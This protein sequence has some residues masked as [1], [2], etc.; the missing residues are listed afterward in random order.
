MPA[1]PLPGLERKPYLSRWRDDSFEMD[2]DRAPGLSG[3][4][5]SSASAALG[6]LGPLGSSTLSVH[7]PPRSAS[8]NVALGSSGVMTASARGVGGGAGG[9]S[10][11]PDASPLI[12]RRKVSTVRS[13]WLERS[14]NVEDFV[15]EID[16]APTPA[17]SAAPTPAMGGG[18]T[19]TKDADGAGPG[20]GPGM[21]PGAGGYPTPP[22]SLIHI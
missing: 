7:P 17:S 16:G 13:R 1:L 12:T 15:D 3:A 10:P 22:L 9:N 19:L 14:N 11:A 8:A 6:T 20:P 5:G 21:G 4:G 18:R 2:E